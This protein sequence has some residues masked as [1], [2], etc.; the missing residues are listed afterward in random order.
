VH[1]NINDILSIDDQLSPTELDFRSRIRGLVDQEIRPYVGEWFANATFPTEL[2]P[3]LGEAEMFGTTLHGYNCPG[4]SAVEYGLGALELEAGDSGIR[5]L[6]SVQG[7]LAMNAIHKWGSEEQKTTCL[8]AM[9]RGELVGCFGLTEPTAGSDPASMT[10]TATRDGDDWILTG[11]KR[12]IGLASIAQIAVIW[13]RTVDGVRGFVVPTATEGFS[14]VPIPR[15]LSLRT[16]IQCDITL[17]SVRVPENAM[18]PKATGLGA[19]LACLNDARYGIA[20]GAIGAARDSYE[21]AVT[22]AQNRTQFD[23]PIASFQ[24]TQAKLVDMMIAVQT[25][26]LLALHL[27]RLKDKGALTP[28]QVSLA[29]LSNVR[30]AIEV[31]REARTIFG[32]NGVTTDH[33]PLRHSLNLDSV[34]TYEGTDEMHTLILGQTITG[35]PAFR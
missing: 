32:G 23:A 31:C 9:A 19:A 27:G 22:Y 11:S 10:T 30:N 7:S 33:S 29:K 14:A 3:A 6:V 15:K 25:G 26:T 5:T 2:I 34:R 21:A 17:E 13:A 1:T 8:P 28:A 24:L 18:L 35:I 4:R 16:S 12:W 20:W